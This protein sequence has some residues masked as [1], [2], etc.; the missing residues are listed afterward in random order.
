MTDPSAPRPVERRRYPRLTPGHDVKL[1][2]PVVANAEV[3]D[4]SSRGALISTN[5]A[6]QIGQRAH[7]RIL[8]HREPFSGW[9]EVRRLEMGT[10]TGTEQRHRVGATFTALD[11][12]SQRTLQRFV[13]GPEV[14]ERKAL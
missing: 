9:V 13:A 7:L 4:I 12:K 2:V 5:A 8:L 11:D 3:L 14:P 6:L 10:E 1:S